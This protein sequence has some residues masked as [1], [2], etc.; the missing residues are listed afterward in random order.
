[1]KKVL[2]LAN[3]GG[4]LLHFRGELLE[5]LRADYEV[6]AAI[7]NEEFREELEALGCRIVI[8]P[9][10]RRGVNPVADFRLLLAY[11]KLMRSLK[12]DCVLT[13]TIKPNVYGGLAAR[14]CGCPVIANITGLGSAVENPGLMQFVT[15]RLYRLG[16]S[17]ASC[18]MFQNTANKA[19][20]AQKRILRKGT[21]THQLNGSG[22]NLRHYTC[23]PY[24]QGE[25][26]NFLFV[27]RVIPEKG[28]DLYLA[29]ADAIHARH[30]ETVFHICGRYDD[31]KYAGIL[32]DEKRRDYI[33]YHGIQKQ[34]KPFY[35]LA[36]CI[37]HPSYYPE[38]M[39]NVLQEAAATGRPVITTDRSGCREV[40]ED[41]R[42][43]LLI[44]MRDE[45]ALIG[46]LERFLAMPREERARMGLAAREKVEREFSRQRVVD[47]YTREIRG[48]V[49]E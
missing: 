39:S 26:V 27:G 7:P 13:Y 45:A 47:I 5:A 43:G 34:M 49:K 25:A 32:A 35:E 8:I 22:V 19:F 10:S 1:M 21:R 29:A 15:T 36:D 3:S 9:L 4:G 20:F 6:T 11:R 18:V 40:V 31:P 24:P 17:R 42:T 14:L 2:I 16:L 12:P 28:V 48:L 38:G 37:V 41:G 23:A 44:P 33:V 46:A 30:P